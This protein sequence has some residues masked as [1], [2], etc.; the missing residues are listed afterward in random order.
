MTSMAPESRASVNAD[1][2]DM[3]RVA[4][5]GEWRIRPDFASVNWHE[6]GADE[7]AATLIEQGVAIEAG[8]WTDI[9][10]ERWAASPYRDQCIRALVELPHGADAAAAEHTAS[11]LLALM[12]ERNVG[13][14]PVLLH[15]NGSTAWPMVQRA[16]RIG[17]QTRIGL[18]DALM[19]PDGSVA[20]D[21]AA[22]VRAAI[23]LCESE[24]ASR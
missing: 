9:A 2:T 1:T 24:A 8:L 14:V 19:L 16:A 17:V 18:E 21:N 5:I 15:G 20:P 22:L 10:I 3:M 12:S 4:A 7:V 23:E 13:A 6:D 11:V